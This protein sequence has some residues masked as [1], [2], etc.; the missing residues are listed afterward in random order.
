MRTSLQPRDNESV[1][2]TRAAYFFPDVIRDGNTRPA[3]NNP[4]PGHDCSMAGAEDKG[5]ANC[6]RALRR[7]TIASSARGRASASDSRTINRR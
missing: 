2:V 4:E 3:C 6:P 5:Q 1:P 7:D